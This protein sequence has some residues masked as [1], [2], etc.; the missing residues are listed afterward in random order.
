MMYVNLKRC[1]NASYAYTS[2]YST[3]LY[4]TLIY[5]TLPYRTV[6]YRI[7]YVNATHAIAVLTSHCK[8]NQKKINFQGLNS[9]EIVLC[10]S[11]EYSTSLQFSYILCTFYSLSFSLSFSFADNY[12]TIERIDKDGPMADF[13]KWCTHKDTDN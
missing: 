1:I 4:F 9:L 11:A 8:Q 2:F 10:F 12:F 5:F 7:I 13:T 6:P 3:L